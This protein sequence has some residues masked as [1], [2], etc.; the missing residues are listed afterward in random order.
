LATTSLAPPTTGARKARSGRESFYGH[1][2]S[3]LQQIGLPALHQAGFTGKGVIIGVLDTG[4]RKTHEVFNHAE[5]PLRVVAEWDFVN[6]DANTDI[7]PG[8]TPEQHEHGTYI[9]AILAAYKPG[10]LVGAAYDASYI[11]C[12]VEEVPDEYNGEE[13]FFVAGLE[14]IETNGGDVATS[15]VVIYVGYTPDELNGST[16]PMTKA[17]NA[18]TENGLHFCQGAGNMGHDTDPTTNHLLPPA[19]AFHAITCGAVL[20]D[21]SIAPTSSDGPTADGRVKP[22]VL[23][24][25]V[26]VWTVSADGN[27]GYRTVSGTSAATPQLCAAVACLLQARPGWNV[28]RMRSALFTTADGYTANLT[29]DPAFVRG[30]GVI[31]AASALHAQAI[32]TSP[33]WRSVAIAVLLLAIGLI[34]FMRFLAVRV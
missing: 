13:D 11:L 30:Y 21:G 5:H 20:E 9:L 18:A 12:K 28:G 27:R 17:V 14:F 19:D 23:T 26:D 29:F 25:G 34:V 16:S 24:R 15:S 7:E 8:D 22:E 6:D 31:S 32:G 3:Q 33:D 2:E 10:E 1:S 4:F